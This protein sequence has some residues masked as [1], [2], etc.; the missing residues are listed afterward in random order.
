[1]VKKR[2]EFRNGMLRL[3]EKAHYDA[4]SESSVWLSLSPTDSTDFQESGSNE[5]RYRI[6]PRPTKLNVEQARAAKFSKRIA[7]KSNGSRALGLA[8]EKN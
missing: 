7:N 6:I 3:F 5:K 2:S 4:S 1:M 8:E